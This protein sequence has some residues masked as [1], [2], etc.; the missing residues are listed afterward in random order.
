D[1]LCL[2]EM[3]IGNTTIASAICCALYGGAIEDW[4]GHGT[5]IDAAGLARKADV[6]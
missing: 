3:G 2:G 4:V 1:L 6:I 5:G